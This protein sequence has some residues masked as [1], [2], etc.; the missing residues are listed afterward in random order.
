[1]R[2]NWSLDMQKTDKELDVQTQ[3]NTGSLNMLTQVDTVFLQMNKPHFLRALLINV[4]QKKLRPTEVLFFF[5][6]N[7]SYSVFD[8]FL[9]DDDTRSFCGQCRSRSDYTEHAV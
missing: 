5:I 3:D 9:T 8:T 2:G 4:C 1:M 6:S 7:F